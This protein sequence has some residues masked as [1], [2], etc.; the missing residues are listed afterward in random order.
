MPINKM[1]HLL[2]RDNANYNRFR[3]TSL[4][5]TKQSGIGFQSTKILCCKVK[6]KV[7]PLANF[8]HMLMLM[9]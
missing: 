5:D 6:C 7:I 1:L 4:L 3:Q 8:Q 9:I 2:T